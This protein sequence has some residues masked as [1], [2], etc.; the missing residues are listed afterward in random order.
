MPLLEFFMLLGDIIVRGNFS[1]F[2]YIHN[3]IRTLT[4][5]MVRS[6]ESRPFNLK[7]DSA[8]KIL[9]A[10]SHVFVELSE[11]SECPSSLPFFSLTFIATT[12]FT[13]R[14]SGLVQSRLLQWIKG[15][16][17]GQIFAIVFHNNDS[18]RC[19]G[20]M[21]ASDATVAVGAAPPCGQW[22]GGVVELDRGEGGGVG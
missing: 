12:G 13:L 20:G 14:L 3:S 7:N 9:N 15:S 5:E 19:L 6:R 10:S 8:E 22:V 21:S 4:P 17:C 1:L 18:A 11:P 2:Y 16:L